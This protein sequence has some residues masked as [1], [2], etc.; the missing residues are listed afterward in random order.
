MSDDATQTAAT[1]APVEAKKKG[2]LATPTGRI[3][4]ILVGLGA[5]GI[6]VGVV[7]LLVMTVFGTQASDNLEGQLEQP[8]ATGQS[9]GTTETVVPK[10]AAA[11]IANADVFTFRNI[12]DPLLT[13]A[14]TSTVTPTST[15]TTDTV[16]PTAKGTLYLEGVVTEDGVLKAQLRFNN[17]VYTLGAG[18]AIPNSPWQVLRVS[19][20]SVIM[21]YGD[22]QV[23]LAVGQ[24]IT[25]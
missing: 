22:I 9:A 12:F 6:V 16:T 23:T 8:P 10:T 5:L 18:G 20:T 13:V 14:T 24:G 17:V 15:G 3:V 2:L 11:E 1:G 4:A 25:K 19:S 21:L 7:F